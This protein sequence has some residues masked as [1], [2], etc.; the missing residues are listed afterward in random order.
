MAYQVS[1]LTTNRDPDAAEIAAALDHG[2]FVVLTH[3]LAY[4]RYTDATLPG[5]TRSIATASGGKATFD[6]P[7]A[8]IAFCDQHNNDDDATEYGEVSYSV[9]GPDRVTLHPVAN[10]SAAADP[11]GFDDIP[12]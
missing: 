4:C 1:Q 11:T 10:Q 12:F 2:L 3:S 5:T 8:A 6:S 9:I 7:A